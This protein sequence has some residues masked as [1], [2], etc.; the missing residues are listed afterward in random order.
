VVAVDAEE[1]KEKTSSRAANPVIRLASGIE[2][3]WIAALFP[4]SIIQKTELVWNDRAGRVE[5]VQQTTYEHIQLEETVR[6]A[7]PSDEASRLLAS[8]VISG[9]LSAF[10]DL[11]LLPQ[12]QARLELVSKCFPAENLPAIADFDMRVAVEQLCRGRRSLDELEGLSLVNSLVERLTD[13]QRALM[14]REAPDRIRLTSGR[15]VR[16][17]YELLKSPW[18]ESRLQDFFGTHVTPTICA[19]KVSLTIHLLAPNGRAVQVTK[20][21]AGFWSKHYPAIR[22][23]LQRRY[24]KHPWPEPDKLKDSR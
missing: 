21:L 11:S 16:I 12:F 22:R 8:A 3:E 15:T 7:S 23:E 9:G 20:D 4:E 10:H 24:P 1:R 6:T 5:E 18:I 2:S 17:H 13:R 19:G 14:R